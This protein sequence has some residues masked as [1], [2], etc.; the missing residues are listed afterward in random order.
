MSG[1][2]ARTGVQPV[3]WSLCLESGLWAFQLTHP[4]SVSHNIPIV[5]SKMTKNKMSQSL[6]G[7]DQKAETM[8][9]KKAGR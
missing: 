6:I 3:M 2:G 7:R 8:K 4:A 1:D 5:M 9:E